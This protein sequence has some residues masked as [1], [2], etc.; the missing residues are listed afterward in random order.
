M[1][2]VRTMDLGNAQM[3]NG[4][5]GVFSLLA[6]AFSHDSAANSEP[7]VELL[8][9]ADALLAFPTEK[10]NFRRWARPAPIPETDTKCNTPDL[11]MN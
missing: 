9:I 8:G 6:R 2:G 11:L 1:V 5:M 3:F 4:A 10:L 7:H